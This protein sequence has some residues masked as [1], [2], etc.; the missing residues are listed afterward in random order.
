MAKHVL[1]L[2]IV[3]SVGL[4]SSTQAQSDS[5]LA[6]IIQLALNNSL[7]QKAAKAE[8]KYQDASLEV[9]QNARAIPQITATAG[10]Q[11]Y[12]YD[13]SWADSSGK[14][15]F[16]DGQ[17]PA[18]SVTISYDL[19]KLFGPESKIAQ[20]TASLS[21]TQEKI[22][23]RDI[24][25]NV[26][27]TYYSIVEIKSELDE[28]GNLI[29]LFAKIDRILKKQKKIGVY[30]EIE[31]KQ[32]QVQQS[33]L[34][35]DLQVRSSDL[36]AAYSQFSIN[37]NL[38]VEEVKLRLDKIKNV[39]E[40]SFANRKNINLNELQKFDDQQMLQNLGRDY[41]VS[42]MEYEKFNSVAL[43]I[44]YI[45]GA[46]ELPTMPSSDGYQS[47][48]EV[49]ISIPIDGF[50]TRPSLK[51]QLDVKTEKNQALFERALLD[52]RN[53]VRLN[54]IDL[55]RFKDQSGALGDTRK[56]TKKLLDKSFV[57]YSQKRIDVLGTLD[58]FQKYLQTTR[59]VLVNNLQIENIDAE[60]EYLVGGAQL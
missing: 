57:F 7:D 17:K 28:L 21:R 12:F 56:E 59:N 18:Y 41:N 47:I 20:Q 36:E 16:N 1:F 27:K 4:S 46:R 6:S 37:L 50:F 54:L 45:K 52:Y 49:G 35:T 32:F 39:P 33:I 13:S 55:K 44:I 29:T 3:L 2:I 58:I 9:A 42:K 43:P 25:R 5:S 48:V 22:V 53:Q 14:P 24:I 15:V 51:S 26:K 10:Y 31:R 40:L 11:R 8:I 34:S 60:L 38:S 30:N 19:Q 23:E